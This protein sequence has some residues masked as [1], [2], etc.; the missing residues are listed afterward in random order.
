MLV[1]SSED[2]TGSWGTL[3]AVVAVEVICWYATSYKLLNSCTFEARFSLH[4]A[5]IVCVVFLCPGVQL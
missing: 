5:V 1:R 3:A 4:V 2:Q